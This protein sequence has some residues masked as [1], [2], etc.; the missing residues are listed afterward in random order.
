MSS[1]SGSF[2]VG[3][4]EEFTVNR[5]GGGLRIRWRW[6]SSIYLFLAVFCIA[7]DSFLVVWYQQAMG[8]DA[9]TIEWFLVLFPLAHVGVGVSLTYFTL[10]GLLNST[11]VAL[12]AGQLRVRHGP[13]PWK[14]NRTVPRY[15]LAQLFCLELQSED[16][17]R[18]GY[19]LMARL[20]SGT[21]IKLVRRLPSR[22]QAKFLER[23]IE[24]AAGIENRPV[25]GEAAE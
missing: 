9:E 15:D 23:E 24:R 8:E 5:Y 3:R 25:A 18:S 4:P 22:R 6:Y 16:E 1:T 20:H 10:A 17:P 13:L 2:D 14:G 7:W 21:E 11:E 12:E 19:D